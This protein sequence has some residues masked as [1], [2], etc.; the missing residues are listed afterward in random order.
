MDFVCADVFDLLTD[1]ESNRKHGYDYIILDP[2]AFTKSR[3]TI[4]SAVK[5]YKAINAKAMK[6]LPRG[7][8]LLTCSCSHFM[9]DELS[10][11]CFTMPQRM[12]GFSCVKSKRVSRL[13]ITRFFGMYPRRII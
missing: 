11:R 7:G 6:L 10:V 12:Q 5:G 9:T 8:Y 4:G 1:M 13:L 2:P 3:D